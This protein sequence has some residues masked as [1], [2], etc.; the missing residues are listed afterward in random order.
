MGRGPLRSAVIGNH[1]CPAHVAPQA[2][3][4]KRADD[5]SSDE[6]MR[7]VVTDGSGGGAS[8]AGLHLPLGLGANVVLTM[9]HEVRMAAEEYAPGMDSIVLSSISKR[10]CVIFHI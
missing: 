6:V 7:I 3:L 10:D 9:S 4:R 8:G 5:P 1:C 2:S